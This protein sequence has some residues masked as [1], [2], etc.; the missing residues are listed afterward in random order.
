MASAVVPVTCCAVAVSVV[1]VL[2]WSAV[3]GLLLATAVGSCALINRVLLGCWP[4]EA[5]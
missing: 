4:C 5:V 3:F 1:D 2:G